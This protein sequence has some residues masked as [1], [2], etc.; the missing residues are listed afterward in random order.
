M[1][2]LLCTPYIKEKNPPGLLWYN[3]LKKLNYEVELYDYRYHAYFFNRGKGVFNKYKILKKIIKWRTF[4][5]LKK[6]IE[7]F[8]P[9]VLLTYKGEILD[10]EIINF[11]KNEYKIYTILIFP[12]DPQLFDSISSKIA[13]AYDY[14]F[15]FSWTTI[16]RYKELGIKNLDYIPFAIDPNSY[17][18]IRLNE[19]DLKEYG[20]DLSFVGTMYKNREKIINQIINYNMKIWGKGWER[21]IYPMIKKKYTYKFITLEEIIKVFNACKINLNIHHN[22]GFVNLRCYEITGCG[23]FCLTDRAERIEKLFEIGKE[24]VIFED[25][26]DLKEKIDYY[27][28]NDDERQEIALRGQKRTYKDHTIENRIKKVISV[29]K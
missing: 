20:S 11:I 9:D 18:K 15:T 23:A 21:A 22:F 26:Q 8:E 6:C 3:T 14:V 28:D 17:H 25:V 5:K 13:P 16:P 10:P 27:L 29:V 12:D 2:I 1:K 19:E 4:R 7:K 24:I